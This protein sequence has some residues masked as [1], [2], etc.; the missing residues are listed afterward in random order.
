MTFLLDTNV[1]SELRKPAARANGAVRRWA[2]LQPPEAL[3]LS[4]ISVMELQI[5]IGRVARRDPAQARQLNDWFA[6]RLIPGFEGRLLTID[7]VVARRSAVLQVADPGP[8]R[9]A[10]MAA[11]ALVHD[12]TVVA[13][14]CPTS[15]R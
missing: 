12:L 2:E 6:S 3:F 8:E 14:K 11:T 1:V 9:D 7:L 10:V 13:R 5:G 4:V 15:R